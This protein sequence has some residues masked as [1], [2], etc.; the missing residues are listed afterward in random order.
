V[1]WCSKAREEE[2][3][4]TNKKKKKK[5]RKK[6]SKSQKKT[7]ECL[8][9]FFFSYSSS[10]DFKCAHVRLDKPLYFKSLDRKKTKQKTTKQERKNKKETGPDDLY[11]MSG[12]GAWVSF[13][14][15]WA[16]DPN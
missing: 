11:C 4:K 12:T 3:L 8:V 9:V 7:D 5:R 14:N 13:G 2:I 10:S 16:T 15:D 6:R 1:C